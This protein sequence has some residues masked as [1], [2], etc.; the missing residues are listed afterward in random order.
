M[1]T[2][3][4]KPSRAKANQLRKPAPLL[5]NKYVRTVASVRVVSLLLLYVGPSYA[6]RG[7]ARRRG[8]ATGSNRL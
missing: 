3:K 2:S 6:R 5:S 4:R 7:A 1:M 8:G